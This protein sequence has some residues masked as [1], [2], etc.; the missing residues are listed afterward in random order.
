MVV[1]PV[2]L[3]GAK[4]VVTSI[5]TGTVVAMEQLPLVTFTW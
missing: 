5:I 2:I 1:V 4:D 3:Y